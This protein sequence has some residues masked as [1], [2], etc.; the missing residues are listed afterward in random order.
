MKRN[1]YLDIIKEKTGVDN[2]YIDE[3][4]KEYFELLKH[5]IIKNKKAKYDFIEIMACPGGCINGGGQPIVSSNIRNFTDFKSKRIESLYTEDKNLPIRV[6]HKNKD[7]LKLYKD[8][9]GK[10]GSEISHKF[11]HTSYNEPVKYK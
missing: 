8:F 4:I 2:K 5:Q 10:P 7:I 11:L 9:L 6:S 1:E 3:V